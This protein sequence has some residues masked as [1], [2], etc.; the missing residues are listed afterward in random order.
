MGFKKT[1]LQTFTAL[2]ALSIV[3]CSGSSGTSS[4]TSSGSSSTSSSVTVSSLSEVPEISQMLVSSGTNSNSTAL[5]AVSGT[6]SNLVDISDS[7]AD[8]L[9]WNG[10]ISDISD[11]I[12]EDGNVDTS[13]LS[14]YLGNDGMSD[15]F[16]GEGKCRVAQ[17]IGYSFQNIESAGTSICYLKNA[18]TASSGVSIVS[19]EV[20]DVSELFQPDAATKIVKVQVTGG[21]GDGPESED[22]EIFIK[23]Y[24]TNTTEG[25]DG[26]AVDLWFCD[27]NS[28]TADGYEIVRINTENGTMT[29]TNVDTNRGNF[30]ASFSGSLTEDEDGNIS[31][32]SSAAQSVNYAS[33]D[34]EFGTH[35]AYISVEDGTLTSKEWY[36]GEWDG[37]S[38]NRKAYGVSNYSGT[39]IENFKILTA[40]FST[41]WT[42][43]GNDTDDYYGAM[44]YQDTLYVAVTSGDLYDAVSSFS[45]AEDSFWDAEEPT[46]DSD[47][48]AATSDYDCSATPDFV[49]SMDMGDSGFQSE[50]G[51]Q[52][53]AHFS[54]MNF[55]DSDA[56]QKARNAIFEVEFQ[57][58]E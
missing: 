34:D 15:F 16:D 35:Q 22:D 40:G 25:S 48:L 45:F 42:S 26:Y 24:G 23:V 14:T 53:E 18:P 49:V 41:R 56:I 47:L 50:V 55:C 52:C 17:M 4:G 12:D 32:D 1:V 20:D 28:G 5:F 13:G 58:N 7:D 19:G 2:C 43:G 31:F 54:D 27:P 51:D 21:E 38:E 3:A 30:V 9:F 11:Y 44:E 10:M 46:V 33:S 29:S 36:E 8:T 57:G 6:P 37:Q 39:S